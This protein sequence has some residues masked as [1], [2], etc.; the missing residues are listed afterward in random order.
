MISV[1]VVA[2]VFVLF[3]EVRFCFFSCSLVWIGTTVVQSHNDGDG[4]KENVDCNID[5]IEQ[6]RVEKSLP[7]VLLCC[8][9]GT[10]VMSCTF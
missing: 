2:V 9:S 1:A 4:D 6:N 8:T 10:A 5:S 7:W 3:V